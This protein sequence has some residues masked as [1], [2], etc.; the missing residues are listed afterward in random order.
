M[1]DIASFGCIVAFSR[2]TRPEDHADG[3]SHLPKTTVLQSIHPLSGAS[4]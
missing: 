2:L 3:A 4:S 1:V